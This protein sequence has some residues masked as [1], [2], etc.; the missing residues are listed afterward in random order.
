MPKEDR[1]SLSSSIQLNIRQ[2]SVV[3]A[4]LEIDTDWNEIQFEAKSFLG[5]VAVSLIVY[6]TKKGKLVKKKTSS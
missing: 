2:S 3:A 1:R 4:L 6:L 5:F